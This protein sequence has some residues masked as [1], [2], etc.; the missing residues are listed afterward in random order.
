M[1]TDQN[2]S[3]S[4]T[5]SQTRSAAVKKGGVGAEKTPAS[6]DTPDNIS[7]SMVSIE[8]KFFISAVFL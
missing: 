8:G 5:R 3:A 1:S 7:T 4:E 2:K 6:S